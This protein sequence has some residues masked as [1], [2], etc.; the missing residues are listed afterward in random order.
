PMSPDTWESAFKSI[1]RSTLLQHFPYAQANRAVN[2]TGARHGMIQIEGEPAGL[3]QVS[4][5]GVLRNIVHAVSLDRG[6]LWFEGYGG[7]EHLAAFFDAFA[8][9]FPKRLGRKMRLLPEAKDN[10]PN[11]SAISKAGYGRRDEMPGYETIWL[12]LDE[13]PKTLRAKLNGKWRN[14]LSKSERSGLSVSEDW[15]GE[16]ATHFLKTYE[17]D[18]TEKG[19]DGP[20]IKLLVQLFKHMVPR[21]EAVIFNAE[22]DGET[23]AAILVLLHGSSATYQVGWTTDTGR[24]LGAHHHLLW[25]AVLSLKEKGILDLDLGGIND[26][27][28]RGVKKFKQGLGG[29]EVTLVGFFH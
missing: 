21:G 29:K 10:G 18:R 9:E 27:S 15:S 23:V 24:K 14:I 19:Y 22:H 7:Q 17:A 1:R 13:D 11:R 3:V 2:Q 20:S 12:A 8:S 6:P 28:A 4:E 16:T 26:E 5:V 25:R